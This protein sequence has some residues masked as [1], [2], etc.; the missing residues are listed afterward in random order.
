MS[1]VI[2]LFAVYC[3]LSSRSASRYQIA[4]DELF[5]IP[6]HDGVHVA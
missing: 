1:T 4:I 5:E 6:I 3:I 2:C